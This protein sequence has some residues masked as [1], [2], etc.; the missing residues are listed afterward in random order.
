MMLT[1]SEALRGHV[2]DVGPLRGLR[3]AIAGGAESRDW[4]ERAATTLAGLGNEGPHVRLVGRFER[5]FGHHYIVRILVVR[6]RRPVDEERLRVGLP[7]VVHCHQERLDRILQVVALINHVGR[8]SVEHAR[9]GRVNQLVE[10]QKEL[11]RFDRAGYQIVVAV[12]RVV[13]VEAAELAR[14][15]EPCHDQFDVGVGQVMA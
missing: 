5:L 11:I 6:Q 7:Q 13:E 8:G 1:I 10:D 3:R 9:L 15:H 4:V 2:G 14:R 12:L